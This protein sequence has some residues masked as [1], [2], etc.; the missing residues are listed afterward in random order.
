VAQGLLKTVT[1]L[2]RTFGC[3]LPEVH[4]RAD[5]PSS[6]AGWWLSRAAKGR[7]PFP[8]FRQSS[9]EQ[10]YFRIFTGTTARNISSELLTRLRFLV[11]HGE[12][13]LR[14][15]V[16]VRAVCVFL[17]RKTVSRLATSQTPLIGFVKDSP[18]STSLWESTPERAVA[19]SSVRCVPSRALVPSL[20]FHP[21]PTVYSSHSFVG[22]LHP[23]ANP[24]V[25]RVSISA[26]GR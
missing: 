18:P 6:L 21:T 22:L 3:G 11:L 17:V 7:W 24:G 8:S 9:F 16:P 5:L 19:R 15:H 23:T 10:L 25:R 4:S 2:Q 26:G 1:S 12:C 13:L 20:S 14:R